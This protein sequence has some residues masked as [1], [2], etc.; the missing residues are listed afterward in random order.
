MSNDVLAKGLELI[1]TFNKDEESKDELEV[2]IGELLPLLMKNADKKDV[3]DCLV[4]F[5]TK[6]NESYKF[7]DGSLIEKSIVEEFKKL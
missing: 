2:K 5:G 7:T 6:L 1:K 3:F 4:K